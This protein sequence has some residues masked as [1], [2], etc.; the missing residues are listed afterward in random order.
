MRW[1]IGKF[2]V[3]DKP[4][5]L[6]NCKKFH[7]LHHVGKFQRKVHYQI[8]LEWARRPISH[9][10]LVLR[11]YQF[12]YALKIQTEAFVAA[13]TKCLFSCSHFYIPLT[14]LLGRFFCYGKTG[15]LWKPFLSLRLKQRIRYQLVSNSP[16]VWKANAHE[17]IKLCDRLN[18]H[19]ERKED[20]LSCNFN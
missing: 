17:L 15:S 8:T 9:S 10:G 11:N 1:Q 20:K 3:A 18:E 13:I 12:D 14:F 16:F 7:D 5:E 6:I 2:I 4:Q 19:D